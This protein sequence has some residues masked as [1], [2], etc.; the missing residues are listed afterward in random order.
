LLS[1]KAY[2][3]FAPGGDGV[4]E[5][6]PIPSAYMTPV[7]DPKLFIKGYNF[8]ID[9]NKPPIF[10]DARYVCYTRLPHPFDPYDGLSPIAASILAIQNDRNMVARNMA[11]FGEENAIPT[12]V[13]SVKPDMQSAAFQRFRDELFAFFGG[14]QQ[15]V[16]VA[17]GGDVDVKLLAF[18]PEQMQFKDLRLQNR[19]EIDRVFGIPAGYWSESA[20]LANATHAKG[21]LISNAVWPKLVLLAQ[22][23][24]SQIMRHWYADDERVSF[25]DIRITDRQLELA[26]LGVYLQFLTL[27]ELRERVN[28]K[29][30]PDDDL[31]GQLLVAEI[32]NMPTPGSAP[33]TALNEKMAELEASLPPLEEPP[34]EGGAPP[35]ASP[36]P[37]VSEAAPVEDAAALETVKTRTPGL[38]A[39]K[40]SAWMSDDIDAPMMLVDDTDF[41]KRIAETAEQLVPMANNALAHLDL[42]RWEVKALKALKDGKP[43]AVKFV[44]EHIPATVAADIAGKLAHASTKEEVRHSFAAAPFA[45]RRRQPMT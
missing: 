37:P 35:P 32:G 43:A 10:L 38:H 16:M 22:N 39:G 12:A 44:S 3:Y 13:I 45:S 19:D 26:E 17:R 1:G 34:P 15:R 41:D 11:F 7:K 6:W 42:R 25:K 30:F 20:T 31:R 40:G 14:G 27:N 24:N 18:N 28:Y 33:E 21:V 8:Q 9:K 2:L 5:L 29:P 23:L 36:P 4:A